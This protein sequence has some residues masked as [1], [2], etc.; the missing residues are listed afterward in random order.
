MEL[1]CDHT[2]H[3]LLLETVH[4]SNVSLQ[5]LST[6]QQRTGS[7]RLGLPSEGLYYIILYYIRISIGKLINLQIF[8]LMILGVPDAWWFLVSVETLWQ[9]GEALHGSISSQFYVCLPRDCM[10][11]DPLVRLV[12]WHD[13]CFGSMNKFFRLVVNVTET[14]V[15]WVM[16]MTFCSFQLL[17]QP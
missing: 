13:S 15:G 16:V 2:M 3:T 1:G 10:V 7:Q 14:G 12:A 6:S 8:C 17:S 11:F 5:V 9:Q 4:I